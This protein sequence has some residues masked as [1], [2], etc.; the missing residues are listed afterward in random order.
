MEI[1]PRKRIYVGIEPGQDIFCRVCW[2][3][4]VKNVPS[5]RYRSCVNVPLSKRGKKRM[6]EWKCCTES[7]QKSSVHDV[8]VMGLLERGST[9]SALRIPR[10][11]Q[12]E[13]SINYWD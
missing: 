2:Y 7:K 11:G 5:P 13:N 9:T 1:G 3:S 8:E 6:F 12:R 10:K 4:I